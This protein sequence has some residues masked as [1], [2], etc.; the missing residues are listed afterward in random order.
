MYFEIAE[1][2]LIPFL[3]TSLG[4]GCVF[5]IKKGFG[6]GFKSSVCGF[7]SGVMMAAS[8]WS[9]LIP[10]MEHEISLALGKFAFLPALSGTWCGI[11][12]LRITGRLADK[13]DENHPL[14]KVGKSFGDNGM[15]ILSVTLHNLPEGMAVG[16]VYASLVT[17]PSGEAL[18]GALALSF[19]IA[20]QNFPEG[21]IISIPLHADGMKKSKAFIC[22][23]LSGVVEPVGALLTV[24]AVTVIYPI[25]PFLLGFAAGAMMYAVINE[26]MPNVCSKSETG[27][28]FFA[29]GFSFMMV[30]DVVFG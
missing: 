18:A 9:L 30:L 21:A 26:L 23:V 2:I 24:L 25:L 5:F 8:V 7:A 6:K 12:F 19:G 13:I 15:L 29:L 11:L 14:H 4:A 22:G 16:A 1:G 20:I 3:G 27:I 28:A 17:H 10:S